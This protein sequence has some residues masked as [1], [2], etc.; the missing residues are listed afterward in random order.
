[1]LGFNV[2]Y[3]KI[4]TQLLCPITAKCLFYL[5]FSRLYLDFWMFIC[6][7]LEGLSLNVVTLRALYLLLKQCHFN[8]SPLQVFLNFNDKQYIDL[9]P[10]TYVIE[11]FTL[12]L[13]LRL[14]SARTCLPG[15]VVKRRPNSLWAGLIY[16]HGFN[17]TN[18]HL[19]RRGTRDF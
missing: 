12:M 17:V 2:L 3:T 16:R 6:Q 10:Y 8:A 15:L 9:F 7:L 5:D 11:N 18:T 19:L 4:N 1:M 13:V 14:L